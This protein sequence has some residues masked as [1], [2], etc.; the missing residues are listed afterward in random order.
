VAALVD[1]LSALAVKL[2][3]AGKLPGFNL[4]PVKVEEEI[5]Q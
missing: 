4:G 1:D 5:L 2:I 3:L